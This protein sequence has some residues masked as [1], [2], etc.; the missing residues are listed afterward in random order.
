MGGPD[1]NGSCRLADVNCSGG[2]ID[3][4]DIAL[5]AQAWLD[6]VTLGYFENDFNQDENTVINIADV[7]I[8]AAAWG[9]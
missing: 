5:T 9:Q 3:V 4:T 1:P 7:Q 8:V 6:Q 2:A